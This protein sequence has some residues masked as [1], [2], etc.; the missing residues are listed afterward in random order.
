MVLNVSI[1]DIFK[2]TGHDGS[3]IVFPSLM[4]PNNRRGHT[5]YEMI[6]Y[7]WT[8]GYAVTPFAE[9]YAHESII[10]GEKIEVYLNRNLFDWLIRYKPMVFVGTMPSGQGHAVA[11]DKDR[12]MI[13]DPNG[14][15]YWRKDHK[16]NVEMMFLCSRLS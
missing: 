10:S 13:L 11:W 6:E 3:A 9:R 16:M 7:A 4:E 12:Q 8:I 1:E 14:Q 15:T 5:V 2:E